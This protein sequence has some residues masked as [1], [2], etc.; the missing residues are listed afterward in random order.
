M[1]MIT[2]AN[3]PLGGWAKIAMFLIF[4]TASLARMVALV[5][6]GMTALRAFARLVGRAKLVKNRSVMTVPKSTL[7]VMAT[8][9]PATTTSPISTDPCSY[10]AMN[11]ELN[12]SKCH[13]RRKQSGAL[14]SV[15]A[16]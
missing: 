2:P 1:E 13:V 12:A 11:M 9:G 14:P 7:H 10:S 8:Q 6:M 5:K 16:F 15:L 3:V 4:A